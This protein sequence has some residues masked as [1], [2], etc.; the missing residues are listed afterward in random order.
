[1]PYKPTQENSA[2]RSILQK[3]RHSIICHAKNMAQRWS[4]DWFAQQSLARS[5]VLSDGPLSQSFSLSH[6][7]RVL[8]Q[9]QALLDVLDDALDGNLSTPHDL[10]E[11]RVDHAPSMPYHEF[12]LDHEKN[13]PFFRQHSK[14]GH[15]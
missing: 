8:R 10:K 13:T 11:W 6:E 4:N 15:F 1:M 5:D 2:V 3:A 7:C 14:R 12:T 9:D